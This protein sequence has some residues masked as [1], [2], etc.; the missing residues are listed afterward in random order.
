[1]YYGGAFNIRTVLKDGPS[2]V[3]EQGLILLEGVCYG[4]GFV[5][6]RVDG[7]QGAHVSVLAR[8][9]GVLGRYVSVKD[10]LGGEQSALE[11]NKTQ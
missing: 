5:D 2:D 7:Q 1:M 3:A 10:R 6:P 4:E 11:T 9:L 8:F